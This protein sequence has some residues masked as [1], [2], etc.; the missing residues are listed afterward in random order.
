WSG[1][2]QYFRLVGDPERAIE[3]GELAL[4]TAQALGDIALEGD[5]NYRLGQAYRS[6]G[7]YREAARLLTRNIDL[8][9]SSAHQRTAPELDESVVLSRIQLSFCHGE[10][11]EIGLAIAAGEES[12]RLAQSMD[13]IDLIAGA[14]CALGMA[15]LA[16]GEF[17][18][19]TALLE[20]CVR[21]C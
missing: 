5:T 12:L 19:A 15:Y 20:E 14:R 11:G 21:I 17:D 6:R 18:L 9:G 13:R 10:L 3:M 1:M 4:A 7:N 8:L 16:K 2:A